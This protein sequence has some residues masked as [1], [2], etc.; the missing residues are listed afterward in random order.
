MGAPRQR[1]NSIAKVQRG[2]RLKVRFRSHL[3]CFAISGPFCLASSAATVLLRPAGKS[4]GGAQRI[5][6]HQFAVH[7]YN[8]RLAKI[9]ESRRRV[10]F[11]Q[12]KVGGLTYFD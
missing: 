5:G 4:C 2:R 6:V 9:G 3:R 10:A 11:H 7:H 1:V 8:P 12:H